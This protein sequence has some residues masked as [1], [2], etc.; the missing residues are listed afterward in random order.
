MR[1]FSRSWF[2]LVAT[3]AYLVVLWG[4]WPLF[5]YFPQEGTFSAGSA[6][7]EAGVGPPMH[8]YGLLGSALLAGIA[9]AW[10]CRENWIPR[11]LRRWLW[12]VPV[13]AMAGSVV[14]MWPFFA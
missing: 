9:A 5:S 14:L 8:W 10:L 12:L 6:G 4:D 3:V 11:A 13:A 7:D 2:M 1:G